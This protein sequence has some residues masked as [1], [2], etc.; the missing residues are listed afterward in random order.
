MGSKQYYLPECF[1]YKYYLYYGESILET[2]EVTYCKAP[3]GRIWS[4]VVLNKNVL[5]K[6]KTRTLK[7]INFGK[8]PPLDP[9]HRRFS[10]TLLET[11]LLIFLTSHPQR[12]SL[13]LT[14]P[15]IQYRLYLPCPSLIPSSL[16]GLTNWGNWAKP[17]LTCAFFWIFILVCPSYKLRFSDQL[18]M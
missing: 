6:P 2:F 11:L 12:S 16:C 5:L 15:F 9:F 7:N 1:L 8:D 3:N 10:G 13:P 14:K 18:C 17:T 4:D